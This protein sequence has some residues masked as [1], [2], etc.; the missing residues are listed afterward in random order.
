VDCAHQGVCD[1][2]T[3]TCSCFAGQYGTDCALQ[4]EVPLKDYYSDS[5]IYGGD[6][7]GGGAGIDYFAP[8]AADSAGGNAGD[9][10]EAF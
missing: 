5:G 8:D 9:F 6:S 2:R 4:L 3:G 7:S 1:H 10:A